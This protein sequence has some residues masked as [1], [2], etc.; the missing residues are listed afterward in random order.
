MILQ[1][2]KT[3]FLDSVNLFDKGDYYL[4]IFSKMNTTC[5]WSDDHWTLETNAELA[6][7]NPAQNVCLSWVLS[8]GVLTHYT[9]GTCI[10]FSRKLWN[11]SVIPTNTFFPYFMLTLTE[12]DHLV[13]KNKLTSH[14]RLYTTTWI[15]VQVVSNASLASCIIDVRYTNDVLFIKQS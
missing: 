6:M 7:T 3:V 8:S 15:E 12:G 4:L 14:P 5:V 9:D 2:G 10:F 1:C 11:D 13:K